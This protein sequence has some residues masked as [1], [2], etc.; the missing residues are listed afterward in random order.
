MRQSLCVC[1][2]VRHETFSPTKMLKLTRNSGDI[3]AGHH[4]QGSQSSHAEL[5]AWRGAGQVE[6]HKSA[7]P[8]SP[9]K[10]PRKGLTASE[11][12]LQDRELARNV[13]VALRIHSNILRFYR[14]GARLYSQQVEEDEH[15]A[16]QARECAERQTEA[17]YDR[18]TC[19][20]R[21]LLPWSRAQKVRNGETNGRKYEV[22]QFR[23]RAPTACASFPPSFLE[24]DMT[25]LLM[26]ARSESKHGRARDALC[27]ALATLASRR[28]MVWLDRYQ[29]EAHV[30][31]YF[32]HCLVEPTAVFRLSFSMEDS[33][34]RPA[35]LLL[36][37]LRP[38]AEALEEMDGRGPLKLKHWPREWCQKR[39]R[40]FALQ[41]IVKGEP[42]KR[43][44][45]NTRTTVKNLRPDARLRELLRTKTLVIVLD[46][47]VA[48]APSGIARRYGLGDII[49]AELAEVLR[50]AKSQGQAVVFQVGG[51][52][53]HLLA[54]K[55]YLQ[56]QFTQYGLRLGYLRY[57]ASPGS[58]WEREKRWDERALIGLQLP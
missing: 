18:L 4:M 51:D 33:R 58:A 25:K 55:V 16:P 37:H 50:E 47:Y 15:L 20:V 22:V 30:R 11:R 24:A 2:N 45:R 3:A 13:R 54:E 38:L 41:E 8:P 27:A 56:P 32:A 28:E 39:G 46:C 44:N 40:Q 48:L 57:R 14:R 1:G 43:E 31:G 53:P 19:A 49:K 6:P 7:S 10:L 23:G 12:L 5:E 29:G 52:D 9:W 36:T 42:L 26:L 21:A 17:C 34:P 35:S